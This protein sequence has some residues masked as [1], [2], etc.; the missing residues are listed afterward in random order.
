MT[1]E[2]D[3]DNY[4]HDNVVIAPAAVDFSLI[5]CFKLFLATA[6]DCTPSVTIITL[7]LHSLQK[8]S[9][10]AESRSRQLIPLFLKFLGY[11]TDDNFRYHF[12]DKCV[13]HLFIYGWLILDCNLYLICLL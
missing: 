8:I 12:I 3:D 6:S 5:K 1:Q 4:D 11:G 13:L 2:L 7:L 10:I 9:D